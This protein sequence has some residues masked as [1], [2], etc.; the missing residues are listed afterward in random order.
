MFYNPMSAAPTPV[1][2]WLEAAERLRREGELGGLML[3]IEDPVAVSSEEEMAIDLVDRYLKAHDQQ[4]IA[5]VANTIFPASLDRGDGIEGLRARYLAVYT[6]RMCRQVGW[7]RYFERMVHWE[8]RDKSHVD[9]IAENIRML[10]Q[11]N[12]DGVWNY[13]Q[14]YEIALFDPARDLIKPRGRQCLSFI[15]LKP[16][17]D[18]RLHMMAVYRNHHYVARTLGNLIGLGRLQQFIAREAGFALGGLT[19]QSTHA[20]LDLAGGRKRDV[21][22]LIE[23]C[24]AALLTQAA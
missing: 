18:G 20:E 6:K 5:T 16:A 8:K 10:R 3:H 1:R 7:G 4:G 11:L 17:S 9:Q 24:Q 15:E 13:K 22:A 12:A 14:C 19:I 21:Q 2:A 23:A